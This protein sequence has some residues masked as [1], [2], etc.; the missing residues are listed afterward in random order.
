MPRFFV[1]NQ[2]IFADN[3][4][5]TGED[6]NHIKNVL[7]LKTGEE[8]ILCDGNGKEYIAAIEGYET[9]KIRTVIREMKLSSTEPPV[10]ITLFQGIPK[11]DK[12]DFIIQ[13]SVELG[14]SR[15]VPVV[16]ERTVIRLHSGKDTEKKV[17]RWRRICLEAAKQCNRGIIPD[18]EFP[19]SFEQAL[20]FSKE[21]DLKIIPYEKQKECCL[22]DIIKNGSAGTVSLFIGPEGGFSE[23]EIEK[24]GL[25]NV[26]PVTLGPRILRTE[27]ASIAVMS[28]L[29]YEIGDLGNERNN[30][31]NC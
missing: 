31:C 16:T 13:K 14:V 10:K 15:V 5:I 3:I 9:D 26:K 1:S 30:F 11:S 29:M 8:I 17:N 19:I 12:M 23:D 6:V 27:T 4:M 2:N 28:I 25:Y 22:S 18:I 21:S 24:A 7:R 20:E